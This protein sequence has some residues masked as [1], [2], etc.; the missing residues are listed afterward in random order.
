MKKIE[1]RKGALI[2]F[3]DEL[4]SASPYNN[5][6]TET[7]VSKDQ[8]E[9]LSLRS[10]QVGGQDFKEAPIKTVNDLQRNVLYY[11]ITP[12]DVKLTYFAIFFFN[13]I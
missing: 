10:K 6:K 9:E 2:L 13:I 8:A 7:S 3:S 5:E 11:G 4:F 1:C 12:K